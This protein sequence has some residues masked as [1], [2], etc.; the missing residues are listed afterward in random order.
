ME[1]QS[2]GTE[3]DTDVD[4]DAEIDVDV[5]VDVDVDIDAEID[6]DMDAEID[7]DVDAD[8][9]VDYDIETEIDVDSEGM[10]T[11]TTPAPIMLLISAF[12]LVFGISGIASYYAIPYNIR[13][14]I[15][16]IPPILGFL[17]SKYLNIAWKKIAKSRYYIISPTQNLLGRGGEVILPVD[18]RGGVIRIQ[19]NNP[20]KSE[21]LHVKPLNE[22][23]VFERGVIVYIVDIKER[24]LLVDTN[25]NKLRR[26]KERYAKLD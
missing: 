6:V 15:F 2:V 16:F 10:G 20:M 21:K 25:I 19:S 8:V 11:T 23:S 3:V 17:A 4:I 12:L 22:D 26:K 5:D 1:A 14:I 7:L 9:D 18:K 24:F 13:I